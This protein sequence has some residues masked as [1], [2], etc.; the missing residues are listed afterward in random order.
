MPKRQ[1]RSKESKRA[2]RTRSIVPRSVPVDSMVYQSSWFHPALTSDA[3]TGVIADWFSFSIQSSSEYSILASLF[4]EVKLI[5]ARVTFIPTESANGS[6]NHGA[7]QVGT[8]MIQ[9]AST[10]TVPGGFTDVQNLQNKLTLSTLNVRP[11]IYRVAV[12][13]VMFANIAGDAPSTPT[14]YAGSPGVVKIYSTALTV[15][16]VYFQVQQQAVW[17]L[18]GRQ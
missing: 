14:P 7:V 8:D 11:T 13:S 12:P 5:S 15:S 10:A 4:T 2:R 16:T 9:N 6:V 3:K 18:R 17:M 1:Q